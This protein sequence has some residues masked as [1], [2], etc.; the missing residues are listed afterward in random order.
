M[1]APRPRID[2]A[3]QAA[4]K[5]NDTLAVAE[6]GDERFVLV[7]GDGR[8]FKRE[9]S[10][11]GRNVFGQASLPLHALPLL[12]SRSDRDTPLQSQCFRAPQVDRHRRALQSLCCF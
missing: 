6:V 4:V 7:M 9:I 3:F 1:I 8:T 10:S 12:Q 2:V 11:P 5:R